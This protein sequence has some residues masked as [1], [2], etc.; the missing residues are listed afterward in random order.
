[1]VKRICYLSLSAIIL[2]SCN[3]N[4]KQKEVEN[5]D[6]YDLFIEKGT[7][8][9]QKND[10]KNAISYFQKAILMDSSKTVGYYRLGVAQTMLCNQDIDYCQEALK[11]LTKVINKN[12]DYERVNYNLGITFFILLLIKVGYSKI[13]VYSFIIRIFIY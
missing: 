6:E 3:Y 11:N 7:Q 5:N 10:I 8:A 13:V 9:F 1:M 2:I 4:I 12:P